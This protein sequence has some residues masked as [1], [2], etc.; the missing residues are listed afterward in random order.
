MTKSTIAFWYSTLCA[1]TLCLSNVNAAEGVSELRSLDTT[2]EEATP[3]IPE[4]AQAEQE[5]PSYEMTPQDECGLGLHHMRVAARYTTPKGI[6]Y[7]PGYTTLEGFFAPPM[8]L[9][10]A[11]LPFLD[12]RGHVFDN[13][14]FA[15]NAG[16][17]LRY[18]TSSRVWGIN[19]YYDYRNTRHQHYN[20]YSAGLESLGRVW[21]FRING[22]LPV[23]KKQS[24]FYQSSFVGFSGN[25]LIVRSAREFAMKG[26]NAEVGFHLDH[27]QKAPLYFAGGP[28]YLTG[29]GATAWG[30]ELRGSV[31]LFKR[32]FRLEANVSYDHFFKWIGQAQASINIPFGERRQVTKRNH[33]S[34]SQAMALNARALQRVDRFEIIPVGKQHLT[35][36]AIDPATGKPWVFWFVNNTS[37]SLGTIESPFPTLLQAQNASSPNQ[38]IYV[39]PGNGTTTGMNAGITLQ[40]SQLLLGAANAYSIPTTG[41]KITIPALASSAPNI[42]NTAG[43]VVTLANNNTVSGFNI[44]VTFTGGNGLSGTGI[45]NLT[46]NNNAFT[47]AL[48]DTDGVYLLNPSGQ[49]A[50]NNSSFNGFNNV[51]STF[52]GNGIY[53]ELDTGSALTT[54]SVAGSNFNNISNTNGSTSF[55]GTGVLAYLNGGTLTNYNVSNST[56]NSIMNPH[57]NMV[58]GVSTYVSAGTINHMKVVDSTFNDMVSSGAGINIDPDSSGTINN[59]TLSSNSFS[60]LTNTGFGIIFQPAG[61]IDNADILN[62]TF[63]GISSGSKGIEIFPRSGAT[64]TAS[65]SNCTFEITSTNST[66][67][68][69]D[70]LNAGNTSLKVTGNSF[71]GIDPISAGYAA[72]FVADEGS[73]CLDFTNNNATPTSSPDPYLFQQSSPGVFNITAGSDSTTNTGQFSITGT[74]GSCTQ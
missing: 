16:L 24:P 39:F 19:S 30:G 61:T 58:G 40:N 1:M 74:I 32:Y 31:E 45:T 66:G 2:P 12:L 5:S 3:I 41:G 25:N 38:V 56:F 27:F 49:V 50:I 36:A 26:A 15:A 72:E 47:T 46:A 48:S 60:N 18:L 59:V 53:L 70:G 33:R 14:K 63:S 42:T 51:S 28:Y 20:Q 10:E 9:K 52:S 44:A 37:S 73:L 7:Q 55:G 13:G 35:S 69:F 8:F 68:L 34:C 23:G 57:A 11:W 64:I 62:N 54:L 22:Y 4:L 29:A 43:N 71:A 67:I 17:G 65:I 21:D 6:G